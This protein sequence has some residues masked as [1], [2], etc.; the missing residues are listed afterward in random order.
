MSKNFTFI[1][2]VNEYFLSNYYVPGTLC[3]S[4]IQYPLEAK[5]KKRTSY[6]LFFVSK[7]QTVEWDYML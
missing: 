5:L 2:S 1:Q 7:K 6:G 3:I 4:L